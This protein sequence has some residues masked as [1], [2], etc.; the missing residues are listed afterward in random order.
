MFFKKMTENESEN[1]RK[2]TI[3]GFYIYL[4]VIAVSLLS[5]VLFDKQLLSLAMIFWL[6]LLGAFLVQF[7]LNLKDRRRGIH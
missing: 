5:E 7:I 2:A 3:C 4:L 6:G 1:W